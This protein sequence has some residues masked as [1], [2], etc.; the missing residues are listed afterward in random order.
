MCPCCIVK[1][2]GPLQ[3]LRQYFENSSLKTRSE[4]I[5]QLKPYISGVRKGKWRN[6]KNLYG[7]HWNRGV[8]HQELV[9]LDCLHPS[10]SSSQGILANTIEKF[11]PSTWQHLQWGKHQWWVL[12]GQRCEFNVDSK[13]RIRLGKKTSLEL[14]IDRILLHVICETKF[15]FHETGINIFFF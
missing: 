6:S 10:K 13:A 8:S 4:V 3:A 9:F 1:V 2:H 7:R 11:R 12:Y 14:G 5:L 15:L